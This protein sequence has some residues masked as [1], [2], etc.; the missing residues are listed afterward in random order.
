MSKE[1]RDLIAKFIW[2]YY[3]FPWPFENTKESY[4]SVAGS[5]KKLI[6]R[7][8]ENLIEHLSSQGYHIT[9]ESN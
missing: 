6:N 4:F 9:K 5:Q 2:E 8:I 1:I 3:K 7:C